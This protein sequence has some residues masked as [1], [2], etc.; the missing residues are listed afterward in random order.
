MDC[1]VVDGIRDDSPLSSS[2]RVG[3]V[4]L[5]VGAV[6]VPSGAGV[7]F[8]QA[9]IVRGQRPIKL[10]FGRRQELTHCFEGS[11]M[12]LSIN[13]G[14]TASAKVVV[15]TAVSKTC[16][17][18]VRVGDEIV[19]VDGRRLQRQDI[20]TREYFEQFKQNLAQRRPI[21]VTF[22]RGRC[23]SGMPSKK[24]RRGYRTK[25]STAARSTPMCCG[26]SSCSTS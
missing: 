23:L 20:A 3:D 12:G 16:A 14:D 1:L 17:V 25:G 24:K 9:Q 11:S 26:D 18:D 7:D 5:S 22:A 2:V 4:L 21:A 13:V 10:S 15:V 19:A 8:V 6:H